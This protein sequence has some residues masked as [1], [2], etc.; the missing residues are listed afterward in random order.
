MD[1]WERIPLMIIMLLIVIA[2]SIYVGIKAGV[3]S[4]QTSNYQNVSNKVFGVTPKII[5]Y[6]AI[7]GS[8]YF[9]YINTT[10]NR[11]CVENIISAEGWGLKE[12]QLSSVISQYNTN[13]RLLQAKCNQ[14]D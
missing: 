7:N 6:T 9:I 3:V 11:W 12:P 8:I 4:I 14:S 1:D 5:N 10:R 2:L 13:Y